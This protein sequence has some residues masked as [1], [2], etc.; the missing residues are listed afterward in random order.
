MNYL[1]VKIIEQFSI[2]Q[3]MPFLCKKHVIKVAIEHLII[4]YLILQF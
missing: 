4:Q 2:L 1:D 3:N